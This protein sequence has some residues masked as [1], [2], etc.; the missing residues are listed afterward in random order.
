LGFL[1][2]LAVAPS[3]NARAATGEPPLLS[4]QRD[5]SDSILTEH[6]EINLADDVSVAF[7]DSDEMLRV[8]IEQR[9]FGLDHITIRP[10]VFSS[11][12]R[13]L[14]SVISPPLLV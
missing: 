5:Y 6:V 2:V 3:L 14:R 9:A 4:Y 13:N 10:K 1:S 7:E 12:V 11:A 8:D